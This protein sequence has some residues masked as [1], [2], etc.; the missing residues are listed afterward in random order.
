MCVYVCVGGEVWVGVDVGGDDGWGRRMQSWLVRC[1]DWIG[2]YC[3]C[4]MYVHVHVHVLCA[5]IMCMCILAR[6][7]ITISPRT[8]TVGMTMMETG[9]WLAIGWL[10]YRGNWPSC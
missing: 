1:V 6:D 8:R 2:S 9:P 4:C 10:F 7:T 3:Y 5:C